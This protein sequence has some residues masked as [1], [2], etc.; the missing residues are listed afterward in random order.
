MNTIERMTKEIV[1][2]SHIKNEENVKNRLLSEF[3]LSGINVLDDF[4]N[5]KKKN[6]IDYF[7]HNENMDK[8]YT[9]TDSFLF[10]LAAW[11]CTY[12]RLQWKINILNDIQTRFKKK[13]N[14]KILIIGDGLGFDSLFLQ[15]NLINA[16]I[17]YFEFKDSKSWNFA[18]NMFNDKIA[19]QGE[20]VMIGELENIKTNYYDIV[21]CLE[22]LEHLPEPKI[23]I[24]NMY[25]YLNKVGFVYESESFGAIELLRPTHLISNNKYVGK[26]INLFEKASF[27]YVNR[28]SP[29]IYIFSKNRENKS[30]FIEYFSRKIKNFASHVLFKLKFKIDIKSLDAK[31]IKLKKE[32]SLLDER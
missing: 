14:I 19:G 11:H 15:Q 7:Q 32:L 27:F 10:E 20:V 28:I 2:Y 30:N 18:K 5:F 26:I 12:D 22:V 25:N 21:I 23:V 24:E 17:S 16:N 1:K 29:R 6:D 8:F 4:Y 3:T 9:E 13:Q 31:Y